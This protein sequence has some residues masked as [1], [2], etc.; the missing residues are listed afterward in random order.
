MLAACRDYSLSLGNGVYASIFRAIFAAFGQHARAFLAGN[1]LLV[2][3]SFWVSFH[4]EFSLPE[5]RCGSC[6][7]ISFCTMRLTNV[8]GDNIV[9][10]RLKGT[11]M[12]LWS[13]AQ[14]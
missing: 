13:T 2:W 8:W 3:M 7:L 10:Y 12:I 14:G 5:T 9:V 1:G 4:L 6:W 11:L